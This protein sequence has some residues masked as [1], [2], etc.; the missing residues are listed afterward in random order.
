MNEMTFKADT[1][2]QDQKADLTATSNAPFLV[3]G[4][5]V[6]QTK[7]DLLKK[8]TNA[9]THIKTLEEEAAA[10]KAKEQAEAAEVNKGMLKEVLEAI[11]QN[12]KKAELTVQTS[13]PELN[14]EVIVAKVLDKLSSGKKDE[15]MDKSM[16]LAREKL[17][18][19]YVTKVQ[20]KA[21]ELG[22]DMDYVDN[23]AKASPEAFEKLFLP[24][25]SASN[26]SF[27]AA[28]TTTVKTLDA[29]SKQNKEESYSIAR[30]TEHAAK[31][32]IVEL[33]QKYG[34]YD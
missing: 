31:K 34:L 6:Y 8:I 17:G 18:D 10:R 14:E 19:N 33:G 5:R 4:D 22:L 9:D 28:A 24:T 16:V 15:N 2:S 30:L 32:K 12:G 26:T 3:I 23:L 11:K 20:A 25:T 1:N 13:T 29:D 21:K 7:E 27:K